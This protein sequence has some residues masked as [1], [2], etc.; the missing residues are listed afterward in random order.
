MTTKI[1]LFHLVKSN[2]C[3]FSLSQSSWKSE[4][5]ADDANK[6][7][8]RIVKHNLTDFLT[9]YIN[10]HLRIHSRASQSIFKRNL[11]TVSPKKLCRIT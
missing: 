10:L 9:H 4:K 8:N 2:L 1:N 3:Y 6:V 7:Q 11:F 5:L